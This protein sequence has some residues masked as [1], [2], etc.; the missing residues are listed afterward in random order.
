M[1]VTFN[2]KDCVFDP[3]IESRQLLNNS[4]EFQ[5]TITISRDVWVSIIHRHCVKRISYTLRIGWLPCKKASRSKY[6]K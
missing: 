3:E 6:K 5:L 1:T 2:L 4:P